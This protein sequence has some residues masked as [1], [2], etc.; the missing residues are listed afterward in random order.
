MKDRVKKKLKAKQILAQQKAKPIFPFAPKFRQKEYEMPVE[1]Q[2][3]LTIL[4]ELIENRDRHEKEIPNLP[5][6]LQKQAK[7]VLHDLS[8]QIEII[9]QKLADEYERYQA[10]KQ[11]EDKISEAIEKGMKATVELFIIIRRDKPHLFEKFKKI[12][13]QDMIPEEEQEFYDLVA[14]REEEIAKEA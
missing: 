1:Y 8:K 13:L 14:I 12:V 5:P 7:P 2:Q 10:E 11:R 9:E 4:A 6:N 3:Q